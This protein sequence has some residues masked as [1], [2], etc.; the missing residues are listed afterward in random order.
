MGQHCW[1]FIAQ[2]GEAAQRSRDRSRAP[3]FPNALGHSGRGRFVGGSAEIARSRIEPLGAAEI[4]KGH[5]GFLLR[6]Y[7]AL[8][9][10]F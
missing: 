7:M 2:C 4:G 1:P 3:S 6:H 9:F 8:A 5:V 10:I